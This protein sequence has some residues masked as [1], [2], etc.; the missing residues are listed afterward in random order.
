MAQQ[1]PDDCVYRVST[2]GASSFAAGSLAGAMAA[3]W[4]DVPVVLRDK[5][6]PALKRT[7]RSADPANKSCQ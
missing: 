6:G 2:G 7:G 5:S 1:R 3:N 4:G